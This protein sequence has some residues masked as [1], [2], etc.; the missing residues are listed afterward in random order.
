MDHKQT[1][2]AKLATLNWGY[3]SKFHSLLIIHKVLLI[4]TRRI[5]HAWYFYFEYGLVEDTE[6]QTVLPTLILAFFF[7]FW[8][9]S[10]CLVKYGNTFTYLIVW[11]GNA[12][13]WE[14]NAT[15]KKPSKKW[16]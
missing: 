6:G 7:P 1:Q 5:A 15:D 14:Q 11:S 4:H 8:K 10:V 16:N 12:S 13:I 2:S 3:A 9:V